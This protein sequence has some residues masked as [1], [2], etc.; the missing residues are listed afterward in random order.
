MCSFA[1]GLA[2]A[3]SLLLGVARPVGTSTVA[4][5]PMQTTATSQTPVYLDANT[6]VVVYDCW[7][8]YSHLNAFDLRTGKRGAFARL[9]G[10]PVDIIR[11][12]TGRLLVVTAAKLLVVASR[13]HT[14]QLATRISAATG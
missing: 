6:L 13:G 9:H 4:S 14:Q 5:P 3:A 12:G 10:P 2:I 8:G 7:T 11:I 1:S